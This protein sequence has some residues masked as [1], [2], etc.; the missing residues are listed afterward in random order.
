VKVPEF[1]VTGPLVPRCFSLGVLPLG[2]VIPRRI[3][4]GLIESGIWT[5]CKG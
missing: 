1:L 5:Y 2:A 3:I 4:S